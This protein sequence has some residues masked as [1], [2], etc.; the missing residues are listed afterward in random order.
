MT[1]Y[2]ID[3]AHSIIEF[4][5]KHMMVSKVRGRFDSY[6]AEVEADDLLDLT[7]AF[8]QFSID[9]SSINTRNEERDNHLKSADFF[10]VKNNQTIDFKSTDIIKSDDSDTYQLTGDL[11]IKGITKPITFEVEYGGKGIDPSG[12]VV[13]G[14]GGTTKINR[15]EFGLTW[16]AALESG[17][18]LVS[19]DIEINVEL[20]L[21]PV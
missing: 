7:T 10:D 1:T 21:N 12:K 11:T 20:E 19:K 2:T 17:G 15:E 8:I 16:N 9:V 14:F 13:Y 3:Q 6:T 18:V 5:V 4:R